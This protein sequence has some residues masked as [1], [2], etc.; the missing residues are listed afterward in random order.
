MARTVWGFPGK[1]L[2]FAI[3]S[4]LGVASAGAG[5]DSADREAVF[6]VWASSGTMI[7]VAPSGADGLSARIVALKNP[8]W[9]EKDGIGVVGE[10]KTDLRNPD[11]ELRQRPFI[12]LEMLSDYEYRNGRWRGSLYLPSNGSRWRSSAWVKDGELRIRGHIGLSLLGRTQV[13]VP[14]SEC[15]ENILR[16]IENSGMTDT[17]CDDLLAGAE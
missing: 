7:E 4:V 2:L 9:R 10:P 16:M 3:L 5:T 11:P 15:N 6:G 13:F 1:L 12:G 17:P 8:L 14:I